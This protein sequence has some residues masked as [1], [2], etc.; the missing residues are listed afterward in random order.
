MIIN[1]CMKPRKATTTKSTLAVR[2]NHKQYSQ[3]SH[4][5]QSKMKPLRAAYMQFS[6]ISNNKHKFVLTCI[7]VKVHE[8]RRAI[9]KIYRAYS[10]SLACCSVYGTYY[11]DGVKNSDRDKQTNIV[12]ANRRNGNDAKIEIFSALYGQT[13]IETL[14]FGFF[15]PANGLQKKQR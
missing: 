3:I 12:F 11:F 14:M 8:K 4:I 2:E 10:F 6:E 1:L 7:C 9:N 5:S 13:S 15:A